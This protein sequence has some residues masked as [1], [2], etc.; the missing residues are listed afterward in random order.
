MPN[1]IHTAA[2]SDEEF[3]SGPDFKVL[4]EALNRSDAFDLAGYKAAPE[5]SAL[6][7]HHSERMKASRTLAEKLL[8]MAGAVYAA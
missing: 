1:T 5:G 7:R 2:D 3:L 4:L 6:Q 8:R